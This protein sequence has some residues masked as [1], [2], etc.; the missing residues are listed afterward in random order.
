MKKFIFFTM[1][2]FMQV[3]FI[4][5]LTGVVHAKID[6]ITLLVNPVDQVEAIYGVPEGEGKFTAI[7]YNHGTFVRRLGYSEAARRGYDVRDFVNSLVQNGFVALAP[8][9]KIGRLKLTRIEKADIM[10]E[11]PDELTNA[12]KEG[13]AITSS[14]IQFLKSQPIVRED[15]IGIIGFSEGGLIT[16]WS[17]FEQQ[18]LKAI[19]L[20]SPADIKKSSE[21][22]FREACK[23]VEAIK[24]PVFLTLGKNDIPV[25]IENCLDLFI[26]RM[27]LLDKEIEYKIDYPERHIWFHKVREEY[28]N[29]IILFFIKKLPN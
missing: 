20:M 14:A 2:L 24:A 29:D 7:I 17:S 1:L 9:R 26:P 12:L 10:D 21:L 4:L 23:K 15:K 27:K 22:C 6:S 25:I 19:V 16:L 18:Q 5:E 8:I 3:T 13:I 28:W 11:S